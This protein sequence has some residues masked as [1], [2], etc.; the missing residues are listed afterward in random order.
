MVGRAASRVRHAGRL[1][2]RPLRQPQ[3]RARRSRSPASSRRCPT[4]PCSSSASRPSS[5]RWASAVRATHSCSDLPLIIAFAVLAA[6]TYSSGLRA[7]ALIAFVKDTLIYI[8]I[9][10]AIIYVGAKIG[11]G[12]M[13]DAAQTKLRTVDIRPPKLPT[14]SFITADADV[15]GVR[16][17]R[18]RFG[19]RAVHV[20][21]R[22]DRRARQP[23]RNTI[24]RNAAILPMYSLML[25][26]LALLGFAA[27]SEEHADHRSG[28]QGERAARGAALLPAGLPVLVRGRGVRGDRDRC[29]RARRRSCRSRRRTC[30]PATSTASSSS[31][32]RRPKH[33]AQVSKIVSLVVKFGALLFVLG[34]DK[35]NAINLQLLGGVWILQTL[36]AIVVGLFT[37]WFHRWALLLGWAVA[38]V[39]GTVLAYRPRCP[40]PRS[41]RGRRAEARGQRHAALRLVARDLP[42]HRHQGL[43]RHHGVADQPRDRGRR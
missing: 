3:P 33:E 22:D 30:S 18:L 23:Q 7:P 32:T 24:R 6:Y 12:D 9:V 38:M 5:T 17:A 26:L 27:I 28:R 21:A 43:H 29:S 19:A 20:P 42:V 11:F 35:Q 34:L 10:V 16:H 36:L 8:V 41:A 31:G 37:R 4:S 39:Y 25:A 1:R 14:G 40:T 13:F 15:L 2:P